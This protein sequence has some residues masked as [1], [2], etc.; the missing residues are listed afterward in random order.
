MPQCTSGHYA[1]CKRF[2]SFLAGYGG[3]CAPP[4]PV[5]GIYIVEHSHGIGIG[6]AP[7]YV[8]GKATGLAKSVRYKPAPLVQRFLPLYLLLYGTHGGFVEVSSRI[9]AVA[10]DKSHSGTFAEQTAYCRDTGGRQRQ[11]GRGG[12]RQ[13]IRFSGCFHLAM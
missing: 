6:N 5:W 9:L 10:A 7:D 3:A 1:F 2:V 8:A 4:W 13:R 12:R 11:R